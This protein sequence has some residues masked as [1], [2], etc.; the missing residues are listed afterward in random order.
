MLQ[1]IHPFFGDLVSDGVVLLCFLFV[2]G[3]V[4]DA[5]WQK[6]QARLMREWPKKQLTRPTRRSAPRAFFQKFLGNF[7]LPVVV[8]VIITLIWAKK[9]PN[10]AGANSEDVNDIAAYATNFQGDATRPVPAPA[11]PLARVVITNLW[12]E[13]VLVARSLNFNTSGGHLFG[14]RDSNDISTVVSTSEKPQSPDAADVLTTNGNSG[15]FVSS[16]RNGIDLT[17]NGLQNAIH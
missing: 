5:W 10:N 9:N 7:V 4:L 15:A 17:S 11:N 8:V 3:L 2:L 13:P 6:R 16:S 1:I 12:S 14:S